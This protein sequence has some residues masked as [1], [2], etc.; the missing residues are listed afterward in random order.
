MLATEYCVS[1]P[2]H[3]EAFLPE[4]VRALVT[5]PRLRLVQ[6]IDERVHQ[7][8]EMA[9]VDIQRNPY[10]TPHMLVKDGDTVFTSVIVFLEK[11]AGQM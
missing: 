6:P 5:R 11:L 9:A 1:G 2:P 4:Q 7:R 10:Q 3:H 8:Y